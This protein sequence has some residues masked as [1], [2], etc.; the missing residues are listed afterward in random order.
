M[1]KIVLPSYAQKRIYAGG[2]GATACVLVGYCPDTLAYFQVMFEEAKKSFPELTAS[3][4]TC[5][6]VT[7]SPSIKGFTIILFECDKKPVDGWDYYDSQID[8]HF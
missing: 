7:S 6:K 5:A 1:T 8:F 4:V 2:D 3:D